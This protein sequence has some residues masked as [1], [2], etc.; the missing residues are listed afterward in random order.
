M[1]TEAEIRR[2]LEAVQTADPD[3]EDDVVSMIFDTLNWV[4]S[5]GAG[6]VEEFIQNYIEEL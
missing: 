6:G 3:L 5:S 1:R 2:V 4:L